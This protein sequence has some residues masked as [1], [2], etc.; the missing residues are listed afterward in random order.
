MKRWYA[1]GP[2]ATVD[3]PVEG[4]YQC[5]P[6]GCV[7]WIDTRPIGDIAAGFFAFDTR[8]DHLKE[9]HDLIGDGTRLDEYHPTL[10][11]RAAW[12]SAY[13][14]SVNSTDT[15]LEMLV[16][17]LT[18][19]A[20]PDG[21]ER[22]RPLTVDHRGNYEIYLG[23]HS[24]IYRSKFRGEKDRLWPNLQRL[25]QSELSKTHAAEAKRGANPDMQA[26]KMLAE[27]ARL[28]K[29]PAELLTPKELK[30]LKPRKPT[31]TRRDDFN[32]ANGELSAAGNATWGGVDQG[33]GWTQFRGDTAFSIATNALALPYAFEAA[34]SYRVDAPLS[35]ANHYA[36]TAVL[37][38]GPGVA[39]AGIILRKDATATQTF[40]FGDYQWNKY[41]VLRRFVN[42]VLMEK[43]ASY[44]GDLPPLTLRGTADGSTLTLMRDG[45]TINQSTDTAIASGFYTGIGGRYGQAVVDEFVTSDLLAASIPPEL[46]GMRAV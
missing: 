16:A 12:A 22:C 6:D 17:L 8:P 38:V 18:D 21:L 33:W 32:R 9:T 36:E 20:D 2:V 31:T 3:D 5:A 19:Q 1:I 27:L 40:Y 10:A 41:I 13:A 25:W 34:Q 35:S 29:C 11:E 39:S 30:G 45:V 28:H 15:L 14:V 23:G 46:L 37:S 24:R 26:G 43:F 7:G 42:G 44:T 4:S